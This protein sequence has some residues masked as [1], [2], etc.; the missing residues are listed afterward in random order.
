[1]I[2]VI[3]YINVSCTSHDDKKQNIKKLNAYNAADETC[4]IEFTLKYF[5]KQRE[6]YLIF[7][8]VETGSSLVL[9]CLI[10]R[11]SSKI[12][13]IYPRCLVFW[14]GKSRNQSSFI[15]H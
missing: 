15:R 12:V 4:F 7:E 3:I 11:T 8:N 10:L 6:H 1:M 9:L 5:Y 2:I 14:N 13:I